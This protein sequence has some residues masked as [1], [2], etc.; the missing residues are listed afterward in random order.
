MKKIAKTRVL[1]LPQEQFQYK[2]SK[3]ISL[4]PFFQ[5]GAWIWYQKLPEIVAKIIINAENT[6][7]KLQKLQNQARGSSAMVIPL[8]QCQVRA[9]ENCPT[10]NS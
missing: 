10:F 7:I 8:G 1:P 9:L 5:E 4:G 2:I 3:V 6:R